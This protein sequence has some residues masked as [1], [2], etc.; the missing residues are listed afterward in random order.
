M[1]SKKYTAESAI[2]YLYRLISSRDYL[3]KTLIDKLYKKGYRKNVV[4]EAIEH[5][6]EMGYIDDESYIETFIN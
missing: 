6:R 2:K 1:K 4:D 3:E 5:I